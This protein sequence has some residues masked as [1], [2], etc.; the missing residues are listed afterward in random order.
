MYRDAGVVRDREGL[1]RAQK[2][3]AEIR[4]AA[5]NNLKI[6]P[7]KI[8]NF[9]QIHAFELWNMLDLCELVIRGASLREESRG[10][11]YRRDFPDSRDREWLKNHVYRRRDGALQIG[12]VEVKTPYVQINENAHE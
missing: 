1:A 4:V 3:I 10:A 9:D 8:F 12:T 7:G 5:E 11:H 6:V 2:E